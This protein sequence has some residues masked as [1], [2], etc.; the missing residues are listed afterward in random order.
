MSRLA[1]AIAAA[2]GFASCAVVAALVACVPDVGT[3]QYG[4]PAGLR[5][6]NL[7]GEG[8]AETVVCEAGPSGDGGACAVSFS[9]DIFPNMTAN[10]AWKCASGNT[11]HG[12]QQ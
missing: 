10:G 11:C 1:T 9:K 3:T 7:P 6:D 2:V 8:G 12:A 4:D 5:R